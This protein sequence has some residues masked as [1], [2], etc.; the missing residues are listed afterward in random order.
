MTYFTG[1]VT[2]INVKR[3]HISCSSVQV[4]NH[5]EPVST[6]ASTSPVPSY[7]A[8]Q[9]LD[10]AGLG[11]AAEAGHPDQPRMGCRLEV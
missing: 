6:L 5:P 8:V 11:E 10:D 7:R 3:W 2:Y 1:I 9:S 4:H